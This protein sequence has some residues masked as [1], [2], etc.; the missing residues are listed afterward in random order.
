MPWEFL[1]GPTAGLAFALYVAK[2]LWESH[3]RTDTAQLAEAYR[4]RDEMRTERNEWKALA[5][6]STSLAERAVKRKA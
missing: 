1:L 4:E 5:L 2:L 6:R 3:V